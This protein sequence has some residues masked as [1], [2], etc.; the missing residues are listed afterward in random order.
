MQRQ[1]SIFKKNATVKNTACLSKLKR[2]KI[3]KKEKSKNKE[4]EKWKHRKKKYR[5]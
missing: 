2:N 1:A 5:K 4:V 3:T